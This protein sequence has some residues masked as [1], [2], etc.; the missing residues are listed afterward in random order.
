MVKIKV[1]LVK[2]EAKGYNKD[3]G[4][5]FVPEGYNTDLALN[6]TILPFPEPYV[7]AEYEIVP[8]SE[9]TDQLLPLY[10]SYSPND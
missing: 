3:Y 10:E 4:I 2:S 1:L 7:V 5:V 9:L 6:G 8:E